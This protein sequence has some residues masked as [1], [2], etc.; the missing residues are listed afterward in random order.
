VAK[1]GLLLPDRL[2]KLSEG[3][4]GWLLGAAVCCRRAAAAGDGL[5]LSLR[6]A[7]C[8]LIWEQLLNGLPQTYANAFKI[9]KQR[10]GQGGKK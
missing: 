2:C 3:R 7:S 4:R 5:P 9:A 8:Q 10:W 6:S 1:Q